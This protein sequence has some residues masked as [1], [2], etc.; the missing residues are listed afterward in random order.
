MVKTT[1]LT[2][3]QYVIRTFDGVGATARAIGCDAS[4]VSK[5]AKPR[6][7]TPAG[8]IPQCRH[9]AILA[10]AKELGLDITPTDLVIGR[11]VVDG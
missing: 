9:A 5:W 3:A 2:P 8:T 11:E 10:K 1:Q 4:N 7:R 6:A